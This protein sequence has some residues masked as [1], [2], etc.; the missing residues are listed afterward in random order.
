MD[1]LKSIGQFE[2]DQYIGDPSDEYKYE[3][4]DLRVLRNYYFERYTLNLYE[5]I[6]LVR[7]IDQSLFE[8]LES[9][10]PARAIVSSGLLIEPHLLERNKVKRTKPQAVDFGSKFQDGVLDAR[11]AYQLKMV[12]ISQCLIYD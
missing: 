7:Y 8:V 4:K 6:Q 11:E 2:L 9:L 1:I 12:P 10:V 5:Y 3:Y